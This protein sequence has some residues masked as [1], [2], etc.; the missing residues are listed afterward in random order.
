LPLAVI[1]GSGFGLTNKFM[2]ETII[3]A[4]IFVIVFLLFVHIS[5]SFHI[6]EGKTLLSRKKNPSKTEKEID[7][8]WEEIIDLWIENSKFLEMFIWILGLFALLIIDD[9]SINKIYK[10]FGTIEL[11]FNSLSAIWQTTIFACVCALITGLLCT[12]FGF[13]LSRKFPPKKPTDSD[14]E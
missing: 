1:T 7:D 12:A 10:I 9:S 8:L 6:K 4:R 2:I 5:T 3:I 13:Y 14:S 11:G